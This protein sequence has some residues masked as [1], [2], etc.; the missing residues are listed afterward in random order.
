MKQKNQP[1]GGHFVKSYNFLLNDQPNRPKLNPL[2]RELICRLADWTKAGKGRY[3]YQSN[4]EWARL[5]GSSNKTVGNAF[6]R[7]RALGL[8]RWFSFPSG[9]GV[10][11]LRFVKP[12]DLTRWQTAKQIKEPTAADIAKTAQF[13]P[14][15]DLVKYVCEKPH[16][17]GR[18]VWLQC[19]EYCHYNPQTEVVEV[20]EPNYPEVATVQMPWNEKAFQTAWANWIEYRKK[21]GRRYVD[22]TQEQTALHKLHKETGGNLE[23]ALQTIE[24]AHAGGFAQLR[25]D[26]SRPVES[27]IYAP[28]IPVNLLDWMNAEAKRRQQ[29]PADE[30]EWKE[31]ATQ[32]RQQFPNA[33]A[34]VTWSKRSRAW[35]EPTGEDWGLGNKLP[36]AIPESYRELYKGFEIV[37]QQLD[38]TKNQYTGVSVEDLIEQSEAAASAFVAQ[39]ENEREKRAKQDAE[40]QAEFKRQLKAR[41]YVQGDFSN[42]NHKI[43]EDVRREYPEHIE[44]VQRVAKLKQDEAEEL[45]RQ[46]RF[47]SLY[48]FGWNPA[49]PN[50]ETNREAY[51]KSQAANPEIW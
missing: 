15:E 47:D 38:K 48:S 33:P 5:L 23:W 30:A 2:E 31:W 19:C 10:K 26:L 1:T 18:E 34:W 49:K 29:T 51:A 39:K 45:R 41:G 8:V 28:E 24:A 17:L 25:P 12:E 21:S 32:F 40:I 42:E 50:S 43:Y 3:N 46:K 22:K 20:I 16:A 6:H 7:L 35:V 11:F 37:R 44:D 4:A 9:V 36:A 27:N 14:R 13:T